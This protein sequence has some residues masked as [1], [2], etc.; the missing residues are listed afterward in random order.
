L[1]PR[2]CPRIAL[3]LVL[4]R[5]SSLLHLGTSGAWWT[6]PAPVTQ[7]P[8]ANGPQLRRASA[9]SFPTTTRQQAALT[10]RENYM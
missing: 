7:Q 10:R 4:V 6:L 5:H 1:T 3:R 9:A 8:R 2:S